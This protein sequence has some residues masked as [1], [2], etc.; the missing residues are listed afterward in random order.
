MIPH[1]SFKQTW[2]TAHS[3]ARPSTST[4]LREQCFCCASRCEKW[5]LGCLK[6]CF[7]TIYTTEL[8]QNHDCDC[9]VEANDAWWVN[10]SLK[11]NAS[12]KNQWKPLIFVCCQVATY[13]G[14][15][16]V[17]TSSAMESATDFLGGVRTHP[18][19]WRVGKIWLNIAVGQTF[20]RSKV[21]VCLTLLTWWLQGTSVCWQAQ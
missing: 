18:K 1:K 2:W 14:A 13:T 8:G 3:S 19:G 16:L 6:F 11:L 17:N 10:G 12:S 7:A 21:F 4:T 20:M 15:R 5:T 9:R